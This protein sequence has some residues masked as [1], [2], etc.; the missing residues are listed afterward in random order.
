MTILCYHSIQPDWISP[1]AVHPQGFSDHCAWLA[2]S[3]RVLPLAEALDRLDGKCRLPRGLAALTFDDG[4]EGLY[5]YAMPIF[6][7]Y[8]LPMTVFLVAKTL[9]D[10][11]QPV[12]WVDTPPECGLT[13]LNAEQVLEMQA[14]GVEFQSHSYSHVDLTQLSFEQCV[15]DLRDSREFL[16]DLL[17]APVSMLAYPRGRHNEAVRSAAARAGY[18]YAFSLPESPEQPGPYA[19]PRVGIYQDN[20]VINLRVKSAKPYLGIRLS[21]AYRVG[22]ELRRAV[23]GLRS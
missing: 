22:R 10:A 19:I 17:S 7:K 9:T 11:G 2:E 8:R 4:F 5:E 21:G 16:E 3:R 14:A 23:S 18:R 20:G 6:M 12:D 15:R 1:L 13:T